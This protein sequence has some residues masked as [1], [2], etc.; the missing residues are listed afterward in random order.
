MTIKINLLFRSSNF[1]IVSLMFYMYNTMSAA[2]SEYF[3][4]VIP[5]YEDKNTSNSFL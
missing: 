1:L 5:L 4:Q 2:N 3:F